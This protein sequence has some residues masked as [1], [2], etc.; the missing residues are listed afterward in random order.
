[1]TGLSRPD[2]A[3]LAFST[4]SPA[5]LAYAAGCTAVCCDPQSGR[6]FLHLRNPAGHALTALAFS[7]DGAVLAAG[8]ETETGICSICVW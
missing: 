5:L 3:S 8:A 7:P 6:Q 2:S 1:V 4:G